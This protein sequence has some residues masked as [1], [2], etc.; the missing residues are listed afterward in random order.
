[1]LMRRVLISGTALIVVGFGTGTYIRNQ[2]WANEK[3]LWE[4]TLTKAPNSIRA[5]HELAY[6]YY[7][8]IGDY[9]TALALYHRGLDRSGQNI[10]ETT[11]SL[12]NIASIHFTR[13]E[14]SRAAEYW[15]EA[16]ESYPKYNQAYYR[17]ALTQTWMG[18]WDAAAKT[19][20]AIDDRKPIG[21]D[22]LRLKGV[23]LLH[24]NQPET[25]KGY[26]RRSIEMFP[27]DWQSL[28]FLG[29]T[30]SITGE[31]DEG[32][33]L[34]QAAASIKTDPL[35]QLMIARNR[36]IA[37]DDAGVVSHID[38]F[39]TRVGVPRV[40]AYL[41]RVAKRHSFEK[42]SLA[43]IQPIIATQKT[44]SAGGLQQV[45]CHRQDPPAGREESIGPDDPLS[46][47]WSDES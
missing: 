29:V 43:E 33:R 36:L 1:M 6:Q 19:L 27:R 2:V 32:L 40:D 14:Y 11:L 5:H 22:R 31:V 42:F 4:D 34:L 17:L 7:E 23:I 24:D 45:N 37:G 8:K 44:H 20:A 47:R 28:M 30:Y 18:E 26:F 39:I 13:G 35:I 21:Y 9:D 10:Y 38:K 46:A 12:N 16:I 3:T 25:A 41:G 15:K